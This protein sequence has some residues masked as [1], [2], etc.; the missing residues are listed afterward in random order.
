MASNTINGT[1]SNQYISVKIE[2]SSTPN[3]STNK[4]V[5]NAKLYYKKSASS[6]SAT[7][8]VINATITINGDKYTY[9]SGESK[10]L[11]ADGKWYYITEHEVTVS[12]NT[13]G[14]KSITI[15]ATGGMGGTSFSSTSLSG[16]ATLDNIPRQATVTSA[17]N[18]NDEQNPTITYSNPAGTNVAKL[19]AC[20]SLTGATSD[21][22]YREISRIGT[23]YTFELTDAERSVLRKA[24]TGSN[25]RS[26]R[27]YIRTTIGSEKHLHYLARTFTVINGIPIVEPDAVDIGSVST[28]LTGNGDVI[29]KGYNYIDAYVGA[30][31]TKDAEIK[32]YKITCGNKSISVNEG[33]LS[34]VESGTFV[35]SAT[36][37]RNNTT[38][39]TV[40]KTLINYIEPTCNLT[41]SIPTA[42]GKMNLTVKG[43]Y[44]SDSFGKVTNTLTVQYRFKVDNGAYGEWISLTPSITNNTYNI[45]S[46][47][48]GLDYQK[49]YTFQART[50]D[51]I[52]NDKTEPAILSVEKKVKTTPIFDWGQTDFK[53]NVNVNSQK[54]IIF[55]KGTEGIRAY[56][57]NGDLVLA[58]QP[59]N[60]NDNLV[61]GWGNYEKELGATN[62]YGK[63]INITSKDKIVVNGNNFGEQKVLKDNI[64]QYMKAS[65]SHSFT[66]NNRITKQHTGYILVWSYYSGGVT[67]IDCTNYTFAPKCMI[68]Y[69]SGIITM[70]LAYDGGNGGAKTLTITDNG[71]TTTITGNDKNDVSP[72]NGWVL[73]RIIGY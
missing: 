63:E 29:I 33:K 12:H 23:T 53:F 17:P 8:G 15:S 36:D 71:T 35:F 46:E 25:S 54:S 32:S 39:V 40:E 4:S 27:F 72:N 3:N 42:D 51:Q 30:T 14:K 1:T 9:N 13:D 47:I 22:A 44:F 45:T 28:T 20:I 6:T 70:P 31:A 5:V 34:N 67:Y 69:N 11:P 52:H 24:T 38:S 56:N 50:L 61:I 62:I 18:F 68:D 60:N 48:T 59:N 49:G 21:I 19:E 16:T 10:T 43:N 2:W 55:P 73:R 26:V 7:K 57:S 37:N 58:L 65:Q 66:G 41:T 64:N